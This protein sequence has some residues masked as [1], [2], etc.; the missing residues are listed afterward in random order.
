MGLAY[1]PFAQSCSQLMFRFVSRLLP[2]WK[3]L[4]WLRLRS[5][6]AVVGPHGECSDV[7]DYGGYLGGF[8][9]WL[10]GVVKLPT[11]TERCQFALCSA[12]FSLLG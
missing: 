2:S 7:R 4:K 8:L 10:N 5:F 11:A 1:L 3:K 9:T 6:P 12:T